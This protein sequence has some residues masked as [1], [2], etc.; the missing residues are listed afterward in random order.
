MKVSF[1]R[2]KK[3]LR[4]PRWWFSFCICSKNIKVLFLMHK[5]PLRAPR[6]WLSF[7]LALNKA[8][9]LFLNTA[10]VLRLTK[11][12]VLALNKAHV[13]RLNN[14]ICPVFRAS[15]SWPR[16]PQPSNA[17]R[18]I[19]QRFFDFCR[20]VSGETILF[21]SV[22]GRPSSQNGLKTYAFA[23]GCHEKVKKHCTIAPQS[24]QLL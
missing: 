14:K 3:P 15:Q 17:A 5:K 1:L 12:D 11:A 22:F 21:E 7:V 10:H 16:P 19:V 2:K 24:H 18:A 13:L 20:D 4:A 23:R 6:W 8:H 9:V